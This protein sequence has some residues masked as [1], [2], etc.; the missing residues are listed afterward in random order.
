[1]KDRIELRKGDITQMHVDAI[2]NAANKSLVGGGGV[3]G[4]IHK[5]AGFKLQ[6]HCRQLKGCD[7][8]EAKITPGFELIAP[9]VIHTVGPIYGRHDGQ[10]ASLLADS[11]RNS[12]TI[13]AHKQMDSVAFPNISTGAYSFPLEEAADIAIQTVSDFLADNKYPKRVIFVCFDDRNHAIYQ[14]KLK[15]D[16]PS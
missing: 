4:A 3:D 14:R 7:F 8:G 12:L 2:V 16:D 10:E 15:P 6:L 9:W 11:Y 5:A 13:A 1:M